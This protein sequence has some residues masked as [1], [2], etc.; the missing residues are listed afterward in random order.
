MFTD[1]VPFYPMLVPFLLVAF[2][3]AGIFAFVPFF[4]NLALPANVK[5][6]LALAITVCVWNVVPRPE[7][8]PSGLISVVL[9]IAAEMSVG[10]LI[11]LMTGLAFMGIQMGA[12]MAS[13]QMGL[14]M[15]TIY[16][17]MFEE[18]STVIEQVAFWVALVGFLMMG[19][20]RE[21]INS[22]VYSYRTVPMGQAV[23][24]EVALN[25]VMGVMDTS[26]HAA[27]RVAMPALVAFFLATLTGGLISRAMPQ[28]NVMTLGININ[29]LVGF[30]MIAVGISGWSLVANDS[31]H[32]LFR[33][34]SQV[35][36]P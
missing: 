15:A 27:T 3:V 13:Q 11:G 24:P 20:H 16:D 28:M 18:Q 9:A 22:V 5:I 30:L 21:I 14:S 2:R 29:L 26:F 8:L 36:N 10:L 1:L 4:S 6:L 23:A 35:L 7:T 31:L 25:A 12:H 33:S 19:G 17:P 34:I 32:S